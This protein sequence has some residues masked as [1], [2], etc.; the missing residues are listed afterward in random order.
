MLRVKI[1]C[2][3]ATPAYIWVVFCVIKIIHPNTVYELWT[4]CSMVYT[5]PVF[6]CHGMLHYNHGSCK[7]ISS[8]D[9]DQVP[10]PGYSGLSFN[11]LDPGKFEWNFRSLIFQIISVIDGWGISCEFAL[12]WVSHDLTDDKST[13]IQVMAWCRQA[14]SQYLSQCWSRSVSS[15]GITRSQWVKRVIYS[16]MF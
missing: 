2:P 10:P 6:L 3:I 13:L 7:G 5:C 15:Y 8:P 4:C 12:R 16:A 9:T 11:S 1:H 14:A